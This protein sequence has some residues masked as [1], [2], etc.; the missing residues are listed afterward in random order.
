MKKM[1]MEKMLFWLLERHTTIRAIQRLTRSRSGKRRALPIPR[2]QPAA[3]FERL[4]GVL[5]REAAPGPV[6][7]L[8][9]LVDG[10]ILAEV[11]EGER[12]LHLC[13]TDLLNLDLD[14]LSLRD[15]GL[16]IKL[17]NLCIEFSKVVGYDGVMMMP[18]VPLPRTPMRE[19]MNPQQGQT[20]LWQNEHQG[21][22]TSPKEFENFTWPGIDDISIFPLAYAA[23]ALDPGMKLLV[24]CQGIFED[25]RDLMGFE[26]MAIKTIEEPELIDNILERLTVLAEAAIEKSMRHPMSGALIYSDDMGFQSGPM[27][28]PGFMREHVFPRQ[29]R[30]ADI[31]HKYRK[32]FIL[33]SCGRIEPL[34]EDLIELVGID[35]RHS[36][37]DNIQ[38]VEEA[39]R[40][41]HERISILGGLDVDL[42]ARG[43]PDQVRA[44]CR[45][46]L[47]VCGPGGGYC[48]GSGN[49]VTNYCRVDNYYAMIDETRKWNQEHF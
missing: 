32:P 26:N 9:V 42:L 3:D 41:Y 31:C 47:D 2:F 12:S 33:H 37:Q 10:D 11:V 43:T 35:A 30:L 15:V 28:S 6:P 45:Q 13:M 49:S 23:T 25:L 21:L 29:K 27:L 46:I 18:V 8:E 20:R 16:I 36:F 4:C 17:M 19:A 24:F 7:I 40:K 48:M 38:P 22:I 1:S 34:M 5:M 39:Y 14:R 44:R